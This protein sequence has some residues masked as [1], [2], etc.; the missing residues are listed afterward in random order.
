MRN[1]RENR[2]ARLDA[3]RALNFA[4]WETALYLDGHPT[5]PAALDYFRTKQEEY[6]NLVTAYEDTYGPLT[7]MTGYTAMKNG[8]DWVQGPWPW[9]E[10]DP[11]TDIEEARK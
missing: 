10:V 4:L 5:D 3:I 2:L 1:T 6:R 9:Q 8:W 11:M 7:T